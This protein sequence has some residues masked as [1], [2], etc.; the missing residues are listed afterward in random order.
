MI[1]GRP[2]DRGGAVRSTVYR[3]WN[4]DNKNSESHSMLNI[5][6]VLIP[7]H[8]LD[9]LLFACVSMFSISLILN[10]FSFFFLCFFCIHFVLFYGI[11]HAHSIRLKLFSLHHHALLMLDGVTSLPLAPPTTFSSPLSPPENGNRC[12]FVVLNRLPWA[13]VEDIFSA[14]PSSSSSAKVLWNAFLDQQWRWIPAR[15]SVS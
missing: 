13:C 9:L 11:K 12:V 15:K 4:D 10:L 7:V 5:G 3:N 2:L 14:S 1:D 8:S 6:R